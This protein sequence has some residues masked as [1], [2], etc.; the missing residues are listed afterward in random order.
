MNPATNDEGYDATLIPSGRHKARAVEADFGLT[1]GGKEQVAVLFEITDGPSKGHT[2][3]WYGFFT[4]TV[5]RGGKTLAERTIDSLRACGCAFPRGNLGDLTGLDANEIVLVIE[6]EDDVDEHG[7][8]RG[9]RARVRFVNAPG[10]GLALGTRMDEGARR[11]FAMKMRGLVLSTGGAQAPAN[12]QQAQRPV[13]Q[14]QR[15]AAQA[16]RP[17]P[18]QQRTQQRPQPTPDP[19]DGFSDPGAADDIPF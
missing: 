14:Q 5:D 12:A 16:Q 4:D 10:A 15:P 3:T 19:D 1:K 8:V 7:Q 9:A 18:A 11:A 2:I 17:A 6:H 13:T